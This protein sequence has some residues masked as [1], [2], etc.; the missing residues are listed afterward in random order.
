M[1]MARFF[2]FWLALVSSHLF[3]LYPRLDSCCIAGLQVRLEKNP[4]CRTHWIIF[5]PSLDRY[6]PR[7]INKTHA[8]VYIID[9]GFIPVQFLHCLLWLGYTIWK[10]W[11]TDFAVVSMYIRRATTPSHFERPESEHAL[12]E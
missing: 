7:A 2:G 5:L 12:H 3:F 4:S 10:S 6:N 9:V 11:N 8:V 1:E